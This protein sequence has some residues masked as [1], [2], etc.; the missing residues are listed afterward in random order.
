LTE[1]LRSEFSIGAYA[2]QL[3]ETHGCQAQLWLKVSDFG[4]ALRSNSKRLLADL[5][6]YFGSLVLAS[7]PGRSDVTIT[8]VETEPADLPV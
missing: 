3:V 6:G 5:T 7:E 8:A 1:S 4:I 2:A